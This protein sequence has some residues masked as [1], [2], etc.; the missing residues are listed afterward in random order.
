MHYTCDVS[1]NTNVLF[2]KEY[3]GLQI[4]KEER[5]RIFDKIFPVEKNN[6]LNL[7]LELELKGQIF[8]IGVQHLDRYGNE[9]LPFNLIP[10]SIEILVVPGYRRKTTRGIP[11][12]HLTKKRGPY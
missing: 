3:N 2:P 10:A 9:I 6:I 8:C 12:V 11:C 4:S 1:N 5:H 7:L